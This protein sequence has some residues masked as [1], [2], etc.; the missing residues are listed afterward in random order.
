[1]NSF[2]IV[3][4]A[5]DKIYE[6]KKSCENTPARWRNSRVVKYYCVGRSKPEVK[7]TFEIHLPTPQRHQ[8]NPTQGDIV[9]SLSSIHASPPSKCGVM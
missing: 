2:L 1:M 8:R 7:G 4:G 5:P 9:G 3:F 6:A